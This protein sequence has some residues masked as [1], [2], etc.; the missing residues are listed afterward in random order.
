MKSITR[1][2]LALTMFSLFSI[3]Y[4]VTSATAQT[5]TAPAGTSGMPPTGTPQTTTPESGGISGWIKGALKS[6]GIGSKGPTESAPA[7]D[8]SAAPIGEGGVGGGPAAQ[9]MSSNMI[10][11]GGQGANSGADAEATMAACMAT[12]TGSPEARADLCR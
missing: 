7:L 3:S 4:L 2:S 10:N 9:D 6:V 11:D 5:S 8:S 12:K 1:L